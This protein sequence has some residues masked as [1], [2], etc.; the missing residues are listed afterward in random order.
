[1]DTMTYTQMRGNFSAAMDKVCN[2]HTPIL[3]TRQNAKPVVMISL[4]DFNAL[5]E[6]LYLKRSPQNY[7]RLLKSIENVKRGDVIEKELFLDDEPHD[8]I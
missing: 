8:F 4:E 2:N 3:I 5:D 6:T 7:A 1:M